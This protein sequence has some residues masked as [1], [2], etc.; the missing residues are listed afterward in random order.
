[1]QDGSW[2]IYIADVSDKGLPAAMIM[3]ALWSRIR[4][5]AHLYDD[6]DK[7]IKT[8]NIAMY[9]LM[10]DE[11]FFATIILARYWP[12][13]GRMQLTRGGHLPPLWIS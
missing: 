2:V 4:S 7:L 1:M 13:N 3:V 8:V 9:D 6:V 10:A 5:E 12:I 11:G